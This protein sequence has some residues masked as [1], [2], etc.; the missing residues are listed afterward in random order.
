MNKVTV[1][2]AGYVQAI[3]GQQLIPGASDN[4][5]RRVASTVTLIQSD[6]AIVIA[7]PGMVTDR[8][9][10]LNP[11]KKAEVSPQDV[12]HIF[13]SHHHPD[14]TVN[15][16]LFPNAEVVDFWGRYKGDLWRDHGEG[17]EMAPGVKVLRTPG[18]TEEDASLMVET[19]EGIYVLTHLWWLSDMTPEQDPLAWDQGKLEEGRNKIV[20]IA[21]WI[22]P[23]H[24]QMFKNPHKG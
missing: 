7:D 16:A 23:G 9:L 1:L 12:T 13:I 10:I 24:G 14:H 11:L 20:A 8:A 21:D 3:E 19:T 22:I 17:Y 4:G 2:T 15:I 18:H 5:A 6:Q